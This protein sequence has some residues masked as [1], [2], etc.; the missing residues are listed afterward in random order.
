MNHIHIYLKKVNFY[1]SC[2]Q[3]QDQEHLLFSIYSVL[4]LEGTQVQL[5][6]LF[7]IFILLSPLPFPL[8]PLPA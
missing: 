1:S 4:P 5:H 2:K 6:L 3:V 8:L 7:A